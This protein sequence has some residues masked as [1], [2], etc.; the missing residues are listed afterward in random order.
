MVKQLQVVSVN[1]DTIKDSNN[2]EQEKLG[3][4]LFNRIVQL[5]EF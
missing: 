2:I 4:R 5:A 3:Q 1:N